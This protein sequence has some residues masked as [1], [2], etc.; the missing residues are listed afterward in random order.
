MITSPKQEME[1]SDE[2][3]DAKSG[4]WWLGQSS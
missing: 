1:R 3:D 4:W 2:V